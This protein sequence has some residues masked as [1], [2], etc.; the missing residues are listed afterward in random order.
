M[1]LILEAV[2][3]KVFVLQGFDDIFCPNERDHGVIINQLLLRSQKLSESR[4]E[5]S[6]SEPSS[7]GDLHMQ[8]Y[9]IIC[10]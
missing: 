10:G 5:G 2:K 7:E 4:A 3:N 9:V 8:A 6:I 1:I